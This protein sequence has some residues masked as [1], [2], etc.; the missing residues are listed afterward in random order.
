MRVPVNYR[1]PTEGGWLSRAGW[2]SRQAWSGDWESEDDG[3]GQTTA[4]PVD[5]P[6]VDFGF[7]TPDTYTAA[8]YDVGTVWPPA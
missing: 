2:L 5:P 6:P 3:T 8:V 7:Y 1:F 4:P